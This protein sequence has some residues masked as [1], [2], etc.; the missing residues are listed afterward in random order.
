M[1]TPA[2]M[3]YQVCSHFLLGGSE[4]RRRWPLPGQVVSRLPHQTR[5]ALGQLKSE[6]LQSPNHYLMGSIPP[7]ESPHAWVRDEALQRYGDTLRKQRWENGHWSRVRAAFDLKRRAP[8]A[9]DL[10][11]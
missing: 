5:E 8:W 7:A 11:G 1:E 3:L 10:T 2:E 9:R 6:D 4:S